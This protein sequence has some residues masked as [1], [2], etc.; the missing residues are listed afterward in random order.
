MSDHRDVIEETISGRV[1][2]DDRYSVSDLADAIVTALIEEGWQ[3]VAA[4]I[5]G[6]TP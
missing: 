1:P 6:S 5:D 3:I 2:A 4:R